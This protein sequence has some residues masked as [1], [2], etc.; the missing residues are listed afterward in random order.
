MCCNP[1]R[2]QPHSPTIRVSPLSG[3]H[4]SR[5]NPNRRP[6]PNAPT[7]W[8]AARTTTMMWTAWWSSSKEEPPRR[9]I[10][11]TTC[12]VLPVKV[13]TVTAKANRK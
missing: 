6:Q 12:W 9:E 5:R 11:C 7:A 2:Q 4:S 10:R 1:P 13:T 3:T 8:T